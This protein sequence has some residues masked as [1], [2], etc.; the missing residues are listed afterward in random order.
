[1]IGQS[2]NELIHGD[3]M[4][5]SKAQTK[6]KMNYSNDPVWFDLRTE[7]LKQESLLKLTGTALKDR[8]NFLYQMVKKNAGQIL[9]EN[10]EIIPKPTLISA[11]AESIKLSF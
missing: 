2:N 1:L 9:D 7:F 8:E 11:G 10:G 4:T 6:D 3:T 5:L